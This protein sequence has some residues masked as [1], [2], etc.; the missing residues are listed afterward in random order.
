MPVVM[1]RSPSAEA[2][3]APSSGQD[4]PTERPKVTRTASIIP[5]RDVFLIDQAIEEDSSAYAEPTANDNEKSA[6]QYSDDFAH[7]LISPNS[8]M[9][10]LDAFLRSND[11]I[12][13][14]DE[15]KSHSALLFF[16]STA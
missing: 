5:E 9:D 13:P 1:D 14:A 8:L 11:A 12:T 15:N 2:P 6:I 10:E 7:Q 16:L 3:I 4:K